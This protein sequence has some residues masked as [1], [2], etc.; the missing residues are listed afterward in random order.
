[1]HLFEEKLKSTEK[2]RGERNERRNEIERGGRK[3]YSTNHLL[4]LMESLSIELT[5]GSINSDL[6]NTC[7]HS[8]K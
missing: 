5:V 2:K 1:M 3:K 4:Y 7:K 6:Y 8:H